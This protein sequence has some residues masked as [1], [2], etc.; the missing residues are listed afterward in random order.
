MSFSIFIAVVYRRYVGDTFVPFK[1]KEHLRL[2]V[3]YMNSKHN[4]TFTFETEDPNNFSF[5]NVK[6]TRKN[7]WFVTSFFPQ[8]H[9]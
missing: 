5:L 3:N 2:F 7:K 6:I 1:L 4:I 8:S 9:I